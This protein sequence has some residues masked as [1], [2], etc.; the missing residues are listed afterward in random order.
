M[1]HFGYQKIQRYYSLSAGTYYINIESANRSALTYSVKLTAEKTESTTV[2]IAGLDN[3]YLNKAVPFSVGNTLKGVATQSF[4]LSDW[5]PCHYYK[6][7]L[8]FKQ[9]IKITGKSID[10]NTT[11]RLWVDLCNSQGK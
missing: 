3:N 2:K 8:P 1:N 10:K 11:Q 5:N 4:G 6:F 9:T 7:R